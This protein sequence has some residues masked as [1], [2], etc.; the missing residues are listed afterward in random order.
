MYRLKLISSENNSWFKGLTTWRSLAPINN[1]IVTWDKCWQ[2]VAVTFTTDFACSWYCAELA[3]G[4]HVRSTVGHH[5]STLLLEHW[6]NILSIVY[7]PH[8][9][10]FA[11]QVWSIE[12]EE[13][14]TCS[15]ANSQCE[16][17]NKRTL[18]I[19]LRSNSMERPKM[20]SLQIV[21]SCW[22]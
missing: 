7:I 19:S 12:T 22:A 1:L 3:R 11:A 21:N 5:T 8:R 16:V 14:T 20:Y 10:V 17:K 15:K 2:E 18:G 6:W 9:F 4:R 13:R